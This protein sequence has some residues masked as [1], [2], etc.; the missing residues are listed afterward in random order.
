MVV[1]HGR[2]RDVLIETAA[3]H[4]ASLVVLGSPAE[5]SRFALEGL[6]ELAVEVQ[7]ASGVE[8]RIV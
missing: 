6:Q 3:E 2:L 1:K 8:V 7:E 4:D 5:Q